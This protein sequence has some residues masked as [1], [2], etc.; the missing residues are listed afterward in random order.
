MSETFNLSLAKQLPENLKMGTCSWIYPGWRGT[1]YTQEYSSEKDFKE[2]CLREYA[3]LPLFRTVELDRTFYTPPTQDLLR[4]YA[5]QVP[6]NF[7]WVSKIWERITIPEFPKHARYGKNA[8][9]VNDDFL[10]LDLL[11]SR[12][13]S[14]YRDAECRQHTGPFLFQFPYIAAS[15]KRDIDFLE[16]L[17]EFLKRLPQDFQYA[18]EIRNPEFLSSAYFEMLNASGAT[19]CFNHW[20]FMPPLRIQMQ[21]AA[22]AGGLTAP[23]YFA[24][25]LTPRGLTY[26]QAVKRFSPYSEIREPNPEM[27]EDVLRLMKRADKKSYTAYV[28]IN[29]RAEGNS[30][31]TLDQIIRQYMQHE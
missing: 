25:I 24:R 15:Q 22:Q 1:I 6:E 8:G 28:L 10:N 27:R 14:V 16:L 19:H 20:N 26:A 3:S 23:F 29:N 11:E 13:L 2:N 17:S 4:Q 30:P 9:K 7:Q 12:V 5:S 31:M 18:I 21:K